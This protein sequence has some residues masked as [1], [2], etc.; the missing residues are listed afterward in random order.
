MRILYYAKFDEDDNVRKNVFI[1]E[2]QFEEDTDNTNDCRLLLWKLCLN[3][4]TSKQPR[5]QQ[6][7]PWPWLLSMILNQNKHPL[8]MKYFRP[9]VLPC[10]A[11]WFFNDV[12]S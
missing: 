9:Q 5:D 11:P 7:F 8:D 6:S 10:A 2:G 12:A 4:P 3:F 1:Y